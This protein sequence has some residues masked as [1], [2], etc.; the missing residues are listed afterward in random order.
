MEGVAASTAR[1]TRAARGRAS[2]HRQLRSGGDGTAL[3]GCPW[4]PEI[5]KWTA[6]WS[7]R[8]ICLSLIVSGAAHPPLASMTQVPSQ[9]R[10]QMLTRPSWCSYD[11]VVSSVD[12]T[13]SD[14][15][16]SFWDDEQADTDTGRS[17]R[18][19]VQDQ[20]L[21]GNGAGLLH[22]SEHDGNLLS[23]SGRPSADAAPGSQQQQPS[24]MFS[25]FAKQAS[26]LVPDWVA[27]KFTP[28]IRGLVLLNLLVV[29]VATNWCACAACPHGMLAV[30][31]T[32]CQFW[33]NTR[34]DQKLTEES[35]A[36]QGCCQGERR[37]K[38]VGLRGLAFLHCGARFRAVFTRRAAG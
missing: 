12:P 16:Q 5:R 15:W 29:L 6:S 27:A 8:S 35:L 37:Y 21:S 18:A 26:S 10:S 22:S 32:Q 36:P 14:G 1:R 4:C 9:P 34:S 33:Q 23:A 11:D 13:L 31:F 3:C 24:S 30:P 20:P 19:L 38:R 7:H 28:K 25:R 2:V 17:V